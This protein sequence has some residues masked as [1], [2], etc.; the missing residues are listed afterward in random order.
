[1]KVIVF[2]ASGKVGR[3]V[4]D[5]LVK[6]GYRVTAVVYSE[7]NLE[8]PKNVRV[9]QL[10]IHDELLVRQALKGQDVV[11]SAL[12]S[13]GTKTK[14]IL[15]AG[16]TSII[17]AMKHDTIKRIISLTGA[18]ARFGEDLPPLTSR[19]ARPL[20]KLIAPKILAD[21]EKHLQLLANSGLQ[22]T[23]VRS[24]IMK[25]GRSA[26]HKLN[27][28]GC[29]PWESITR[30]SVVQVMVDEIENDQHIRQAPIVHDL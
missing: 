18:D 14:D 5:E 9:L 22:W 28:H 15:S 25:N 3:L 6:R 7:D 19:L 24:P 11:M 21:G 27:N 29:H 4:V 17:P 2:G 16:M 10:D 12:G 13:W 30:G 20:L 8:F 26:P 23:V 1:M